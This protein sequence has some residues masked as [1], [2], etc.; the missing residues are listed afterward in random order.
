MRQKNNYTAVSLLVTLVAGLF[1]AQGAAAGN[2]F[3]F[4]LKDPRGD[5]HGD[6]RL[7][8][9]LRTE[10]AKGDLD[11][12]TFRA[13][14]QK[15][16]TQFEAVFAQPVR[17]PEREAMD[18]LGTQLTSVARHGFYTFNIDVYID[19]DGEE[20]VGAIATMPGRKAEIRPQNAWD[21]AIVLTPRPHEAR[22]Q[23]RRLM[24]EAMAERLSEM[25][26][27]EESWSRS[28]LR[29][30]VPEDMSER[31][32][33]PTHVRVRGNTICFFV[34]DEF[35]G[36]EARADWSYTVAVSGSTLLQSLD[37]AASAG[38]TERTR[39]NLMVLPV[40]PGTWQNRFGGGRDNQE[41]QPPL[42]DILVPAGM[43]Q[44][45]VLSDYSTRQARP[46]RLPGVVPSQQTREAEK[47][48]E[49]DSVAEVVAAERDTI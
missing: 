23:L 3:I 40:S 9:P 18:D 28:D 49:G 15:R 48:V 1:V 5:D 41:L 14:K 22:G 46:V 25:D 13:R 17:V 21:R 32:F 34:P 33:F 10:F 37:L 8:Y 30:S 4:E 39:E 20:G 43:R 16:G 44:E 2:E 27:S 29:Q 35:L 38:L 6:G 7:V 24:I 31:V 36:G 12:V 45:A 26:E 19:M 47:T 11:L 42:I